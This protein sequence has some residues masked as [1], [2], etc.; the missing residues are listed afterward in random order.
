MK[1]LAGTA[2]LLFVCASSFGTVTLVGDTLTYGDPSDLDTAIDPAGLNEVATSYGVAKASFQA[3]S[4]QV[5]AFNG[6]PA[7][8][9]IL[10]TLVVYY[11]PTST[12]TFTFPADLYNYGS[13]TSVGRGAF[14]GSSLLHAISTVPTLSDGLYDW[15][16]A[17]ITST[18]GQG[19]QSLG[20]CAA[21]RNEQEVSAGQIV[22]TLSDATTESIA[23]PTLGNVGNPE[24]VFI[25]YQAPAG[26]T[27]TRV[28]GSRT[29]FPGGGYVS[30]DDLSIVMTPEPMTLTLLALAC[31]PALRRRHA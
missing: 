15:F 3:L 25:G 26:K 8:S 19:V 22:F 28:E 18:G 7:A 23:L 20:L 12:V 10:R 21:F 1:T 16:D 27:I 30:V 9:Q 14:S 13:R 24:Y 11:N 6:A 29:Q 31:L 4:P 2:V 17:S 5:V